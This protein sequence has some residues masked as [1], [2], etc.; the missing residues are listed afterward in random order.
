MRMSRRASRAD[1]HHFEATAS[2]QGILMDDG[3][4][5]AAGWRNG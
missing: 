5:G 2:Y 1:Y 3:P 4:P